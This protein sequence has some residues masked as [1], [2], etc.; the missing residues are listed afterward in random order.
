M[1]DKLGL[2][3]LTPLSTI[4]ELFCGGQLYWW[5]K[6]KKTTSLLQ[7]GEKMYHIMLYREL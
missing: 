4:F 2:W 7:V 6:P 5:S 1:F 3:S